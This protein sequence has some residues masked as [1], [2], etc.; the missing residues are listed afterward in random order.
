MGRA[1]GWGGATV[2]RPVTLADHV[3]GCA[4][5]V[6][7]KLIKII[8]PKHHWHTL[9]KVDNMMPI[10]RADDEL[11]RVVEAGPQGGECTRFHAWP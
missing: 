4:Q 11:G 8:N 6:R 1:G 10:G 7:G 3:L 5:R 2:M 9:H